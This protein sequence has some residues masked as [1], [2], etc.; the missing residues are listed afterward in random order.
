MNRGTDPSLGLLRTVCLHDGF[1]EPAPACVGG[2]S[3]TVLPS[4]CRSACL[5]R[6]TCERSGNATRGA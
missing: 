6:R 4:R 2:A 5:L 1:G 3:A